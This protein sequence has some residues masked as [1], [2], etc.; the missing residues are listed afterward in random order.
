MS[1]G[2]WPHLSTPKIRIS[3]QSIK[4]SLI[5]ATIAVAMTTNIVMYTL[6]NT[7]QQ[8]FPKKSSLKL[9]DIWLLHGL[10]VP[11]IVFIILATS[12]LISSSEKDSTS[13]NRVESKKT[14]GR[15]TPVETV[16]KPPDVREKAQA[17]EQKSKTFIRFCRV[18]VP[19]ASLTFMTIFIF[20]WMDYFH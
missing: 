11:M 7:T 10:L 6:Y 17:K 12:K 16:F 8:E 15:I 19:S 9:I 3:V 4:Q 18:A 13:A 1:S 14:K 20:V 2:K 5:Q